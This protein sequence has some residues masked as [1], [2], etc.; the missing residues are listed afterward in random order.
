MHAHDIIGGGKWRQLPMIHGRIS[1][2]AIDG[3][4]LAA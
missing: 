1:S 3:P 2:S 4:V